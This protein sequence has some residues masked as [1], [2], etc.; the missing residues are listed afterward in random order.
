VKKEFP[1]LPEWTFDINEVSYGVY[2]VI[3]RDKHGHV[4]SADG[5]DPDQLLEDCKN[6]AKR[7][8]NSN[9]SARTPE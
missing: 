1:S 8:A 9:T 2:E 3:G 4:V 5:T 6:Y 7:I